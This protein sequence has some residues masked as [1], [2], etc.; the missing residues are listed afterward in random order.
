MNISSR[1]TFHSYS[2]RPLCAFNSQQL[3][4]LVGRLPK[5]SYM[6]GEP[7]APQHGQL[8]IKEGRKE[9]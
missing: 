8:L 3:C 9:G 5:F 2:L 4:L 1:S 7:F 6:Q